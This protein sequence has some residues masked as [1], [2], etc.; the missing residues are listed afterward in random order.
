MKKIAISMFLV[1]IL[2]FSLSIMVAAEEG[3]VGSIDDTINVNGNVGPYASVEAHK[4]N[5][6]GGIGWTWWN[7]VT[8]GMDFGF[9][10]GNP[11][12]ASRVKDT[13][14]FVVETN[15]SLEVTFTGEPLTHS[16]GG[17]ILPTTYWAFK[18]AGVEGPDGP[19]NSYDG[20]PDQIRPVQEIGYFGE[21]PVPEDNNGIHFPAWW[22]LLSVYAGIV[23]NN[24]WPDPNEVQVQQQYNGITEK[25]IYA[26]QVFGFAGM[27]ENISSQ[28]AG[29]YQGEICLTVAAN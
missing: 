15:T 2:L 29:H 11:D 6:Q 24:G 20:L 8:P 12:Q 26:F 17:V 27:G 4:L 19:W 28:H 16:G 21:G 18:S 25:G 3:T 5:Y 1:L 13:N 23:A 9:F 14:C 22:D 7:E 10:S